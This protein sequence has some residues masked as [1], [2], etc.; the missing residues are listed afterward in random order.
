LLIE[1]LTKQ[2]LNGTKCH[3]Q[4]KNGTNVSLIFAKPVFLY[5]IEYLNGVQLLPVVVPCGLQNNN[6]KNILS[7]ECRLARV[8]CKLQ[9]QNLLIAMG[10]EH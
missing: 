4:I 7:K 3:Y 2:F 5:E 10:I 9:S 8:F 1:L 6:Q